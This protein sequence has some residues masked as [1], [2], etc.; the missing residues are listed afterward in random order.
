MPPRR[1][2]PRRIAVH[3]IGFTGAGAGKEHGQVYLDG[4]PHHRIDN[5]KIVDHLVDLV[6]RAGSQ[7][8]CAR[9]IRISSSVSSPKGGCIAKAAAGCAEGADRIS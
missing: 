3:D 6:G 2:E 7:A 5:D 1:R 9:L 8:S 4:E